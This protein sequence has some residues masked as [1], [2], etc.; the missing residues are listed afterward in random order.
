MGH[1]IQLNQSVL[2]KMFRDWYIA[3]WVPLILIN[4]GLLKLLTLLTLTV[5]GGINKETYFAQIAMIRYLV[6]RGL[7]VNC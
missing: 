1:K 5:I 7:F 3:K 2:Q 6:T 4:P